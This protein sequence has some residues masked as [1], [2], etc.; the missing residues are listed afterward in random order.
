MSLE[1][2]VNMLNNI[3]NAR[4]INKINKI[5]VFGGLFGNQQ[6]FQ[7]YLSDFS[8][9]E[10]NY[11][12]SI[13]TYKSSKNIFKLSSLENISKSLDSNDDKS[14]ELT[15]LPI[16]QSVNSIHLNEFM[17][18]EDSEKEGI[19]DMICQAVTDAYHDINHPYIIS[20]LI[21]RFKISEE[22]AVQAINN[23][24]NMTII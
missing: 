23:V 6:S 13:M 8:P 19:T 15:S 10:I 12:L 1:N 24:K 14:I 3:L 22:C 18:L 4:R 7:K 11:I 20:D 17:I 5:H 9:K 21:G 16:Y 2:N